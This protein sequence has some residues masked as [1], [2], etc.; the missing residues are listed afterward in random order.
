MQ[1]IKATFLIL[2]VFFLVA[3]Q[4]NLEKKF[5]PEQEI[6]F[7][8]NYFELLK[9]KNFEEAL[10]PLNKKLK[11]KNETKKLLTKIAE[12]FP[13]EKAKKIDLVGSS[14][15]ILNTNDKKIWSANI[16][17]QYAYD[18]LWL[19]NNILLSRINDGKIIV[20][21][22]N[23]T[24]LH[25]SLENIN[26][27]SFLNKPFLNYLIL[28]LAVLIPI[29]IIYT[30]IIFIRTPIK[31]HKWL[32]GFFILIGIIK[33]TLNW[34]TG[35]LHINLLSLNLLGSGFFYGNKF[36]PV[37]ISIGLPIGAILFWLKKRKD[38]NTLDDE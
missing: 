24:P 33:F 25:N 19:I 5:L 37:F 3:C 23:V 30:F 18:N 1:K 38:N 4:N 16:T 36:S 9:N 27:F 21:G 35:Y 7:S 2:L 6:K 10:K 29:F 22:V 34:T 20:N 28:F 31:K 14:T 13:K 8:K 12:L 32:W 15:F 17:F 11:E 26:K